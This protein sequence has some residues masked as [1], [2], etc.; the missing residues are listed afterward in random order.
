MSCF[1]ELFSSPVCPGGHIDDFSG[2]L[3]KYGKNRR[4]IALVLDEL[5]LCFNR[6]NKKY[7]VV[8]V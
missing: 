3:A 8:G 2:T 5:Q 4:E 7:P 1:R 6:Q